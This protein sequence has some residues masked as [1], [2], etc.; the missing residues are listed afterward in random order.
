[1]IDLVESAAGVWKH[2]NPTVGSKFD[3]KLFQLILNQQVF[4]LRVHLHVSLSCWGSFTTGLAAAKRQTT[5]PKAESITLESRA[6]TNCQWSEQQSERWAP[7]PCCWAARLEQSSGVER[8]L[9]SIGNWTRA[10]LGPRQTA[11]TWGLKPSER[12]LL[13]RSRCVYLSRKLIHHSKDEVICRGVPV[14]W[15]S[16]WG[17]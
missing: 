9:C 1:M 13:R 5:S 3:G 2:K 6:Q 7:A 14:C 17:D 12:G 10:A 15:D 11:L 4:G 8:W 16:C